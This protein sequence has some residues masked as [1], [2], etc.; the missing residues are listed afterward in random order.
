MILDDWRVL[1]SLCML[2][3]V[4]VVFNGGILQ[5]LFVFVM[6]YLALKNFERELVHEN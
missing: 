1:L 3:L 2:N 4:S 5:L 6:Y